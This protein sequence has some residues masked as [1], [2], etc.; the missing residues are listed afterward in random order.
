[1][2][3]WGEGKLEAWRQQQSD[4]KRSSS[5]RFRWNSIK[6]LKTGF[7]GDRSFCVI[8]VWAYAVEGWRLQLV[9]YVSWSER[10]VESFE[11]WGVRHLDLIY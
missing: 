7:G 11:C 4:S 5:G 3:L 2:S 1:M 8:E 10:C 9:G 6:T